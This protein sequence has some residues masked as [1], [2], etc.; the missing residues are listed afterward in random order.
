MKIDRAD[1]ME[2]YINLR[3]IRIAWAYTVLFLLVWSVYVMVKF[4]E[5]G[6]PF[7]LM[8]SQN[9]IIFISQAIYRRK[10]M[11]GKNEE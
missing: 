8:I 9:L 2:M 10:L 11:A 7:L 5:L 6:W 4:G 3:S 1:E